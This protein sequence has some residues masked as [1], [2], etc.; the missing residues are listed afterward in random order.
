MTITIFD[1]SSLI[2]FYI[3][4]QAKKR[5]FSLN[6]F[7]WLTLLFSLHFIIM[8]SVLFMLKSCKI[9]LLKPAGPMQFEINSGYDA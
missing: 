7:A 9:Q 5:V 6:L 1:H 2:I 3:L 4:H 8:S